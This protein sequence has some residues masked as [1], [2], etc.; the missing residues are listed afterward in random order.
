MNEL[1]P[2]LWMVE[3]IKKSARYLDTGNECLTELQ[4]NVVA[5]AVCLAIKNNPQIPSEKQLNEIW[6]K[7]ACPSDRTVDA[8]KVW[9]IYQRQYMYRLGETNE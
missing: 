2:P 7:L 6:D 1:S 9:E 3:A 8:R 4:A 5:Y